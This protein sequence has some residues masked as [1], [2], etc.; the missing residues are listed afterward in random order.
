MQDRDS[1]KY[2]ECSHFE[3]GHSDKGHICNISPHMHLKCQCHVGLGTL[4][5]GEDDLQVVLS[6][7]LASAFQ[8]HCH[9]IRVIGAKAGFNADSVCCLP[10]VQ[11]PI[12]IENDYEEWIPSHWHG[13]ESEY[14]VQ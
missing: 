7:V 6:G 3:C 12:M 11:V 14:L 8:N 2:V 4:Y 10:I 9:K 1:I 13:P 5:S